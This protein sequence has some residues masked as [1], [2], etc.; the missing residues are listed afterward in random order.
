MIAAAGIVAVAVIA[1][2]TRTTEDAKAGPP[3]APSFVVEDLSDPEETIRL[4]D[5][6]GRPPGPELLGLLVHSVPS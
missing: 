2:G 3:E 4:E 6:I 1:F 5:F